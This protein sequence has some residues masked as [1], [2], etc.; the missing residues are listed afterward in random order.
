MET[1]R[2]NELLKDNRKGVLSVYFTAGYPK[3]EDTLP[4]LAEL[5][6]A[7]VD[8]VEIG[9]PF[10]DPMADGPVIQQSSTRALRNGMTL[11]VLFDQLKSVREKIS[12]PLILMGYLNPI[13]QF[14]F[15]NF[16][17]TCA[18]TGIDGMIIPDLPFKD[19]MEKYKAVADKYNLNIIMLITPETS[20]ERIRLIDEHTGGFIYMVSS[21]STTG[22][23]QSFDDSKQDYFRR[24]NAMNLQNPRLIGFGIS[25]KNTL[26]AAWQN[27]A[28][29]IIGSKFVALLGEKQTTREAVDALIEALGIR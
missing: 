24:I 21:A 18:E 2:I 4:V 28:G 15:E 22:A 23:Q 8:M 19:Y 10:S 12:I 13:M 26:D 3:L 25:N 20:D 27:A 1:N 14:G 16:C 6:A 9:V 17:R 29:A 11:R 7:G 5:Q